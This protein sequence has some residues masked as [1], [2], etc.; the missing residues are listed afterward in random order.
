MRELH[1]LSRRLDD[2]QSDASVAGSAVTM[3]PASACRHPRL[4]IDVVSAALM[5]NRHTRGMRSMVAAHQQ[6]SGGGYL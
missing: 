3:L 4:T 5:H 2:R 1:L 6:T